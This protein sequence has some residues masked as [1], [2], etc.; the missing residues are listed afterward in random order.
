L[1]DDPFETHVSKGVAEL[2]LA[3]ESG[4]ENL[5]LGVPE[6]H[7][8]KEGGDSIQEWTTFTATNTLGGECSYP[9]ILEFDDDYS[10]RFTCTLVSSVPK[11][12]LDPREWRFY[13]WLTN[14]DFGFYGGDALMS[15]KRGAKPGEVCALCGNAMNAGFQVC[16]DCGAVRKTQPNFLCIIYAFAAGYVAYVATV[17]VEMQW[18]IVVAVFIAVLALGPEKAVYTKHLR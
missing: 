9:Q 17:G 10:K 5:K 1:Q 12:T 6:E 11:E 14:L 3:A 18:G 16:S 7:E 2:M 4:F 8:S 15:V 13:F